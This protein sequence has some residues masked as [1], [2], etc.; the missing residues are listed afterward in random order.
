MGINISNHHSLLLPITTI[1][2]FHFT[3]PT[4][5]PDAPQTSPSRS[6]APRRALLPSST[7]PLSTTTTASSP[8]LS[9][10]SPTSR[11]LSAISTSTTMSSPSLSNTP[12]LVLLQSL[13]PRTWSMPRSPASSTKRVSTVEK[14][15]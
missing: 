7:T 10:C 12:L 5:N 1:K 3:S 2:H 9:S 14:K 11:V 8:P 13:L 15:G 4:I 6:T